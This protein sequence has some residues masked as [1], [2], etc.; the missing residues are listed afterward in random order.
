MSSTTTF[1]R[2]SVVVVQ[3]AF[4]DL[5]ESGGQHSWSAQNPYIESFPT[6]SS[7]RSAVDHATSAGRGPAINLK[8]LEGGGLA[9][10]ERG[11]IL[12]TLAVDKRIVGRALGKLSDEDLRLVDDTLRRTFG[13]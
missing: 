2:G 1:R 10:S 5:S 4:S 3:V 9:P 12:E 13:L 7:A 6:W 8:A 11:A